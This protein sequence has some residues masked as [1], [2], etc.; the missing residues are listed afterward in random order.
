[1]AIGQTINLSRKFLSERIKKPFSTY[2]ET[3]FYCLPSKQELSASSLMLFDFCLLSRTN[4]I[5]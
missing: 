1:M 2:N 3:T 4:T 5:P